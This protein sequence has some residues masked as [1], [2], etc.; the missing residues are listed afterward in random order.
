MGS[1]QYE[2]FSYHPTKTYGF[3]K[4]TKDVAKKNAEELVKKL[5]RRKDIITAF[6]ED[7]PKEMMYIVFAKYK[8][9]S[10]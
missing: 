5:N 3:K 9:G 2:A 10:C 1:R 4:Y 6:Y 7:D 8:C